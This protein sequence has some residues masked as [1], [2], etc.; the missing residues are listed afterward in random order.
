MKK[1]AAH[2]LAAATYICKKNPTDAPGETTLALN[3]YIY[4]YI[5]TPVMRTLTINPLT[6]SPFVRGS[7]GAWVR[8][9]VEGEV[10]K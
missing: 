6:L 10:Q 4:I 1:H 2:D 3:I 9:C 8:G 5:Y 7:M